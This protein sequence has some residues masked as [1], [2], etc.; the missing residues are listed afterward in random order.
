[1][2]QL[3]WTK[4]RSEAIEEQGTILFLGL[5]SNFL[6]VASNAAY[7]AAHCSDVGTVTLQRSCADAGI[8]ADLLALWSAYKTFLRDQA[9]PVTEPTL[10]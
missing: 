4:K 10:P 1:M 6:D 9:N 8:K 5:V 2:D 7:A 3:E